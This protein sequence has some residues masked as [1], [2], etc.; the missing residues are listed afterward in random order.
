MNNKNDKNDNN[1]DEEAMKPAAK[2]TKNGP[3]S[4]FSLT[5]D[6]K[7]GD[8]TMTDA[9]DAVP[10]CSRQNRAVDTTTK[11]KKKKKGNDR[12]RR[13]PTS[14]MDQG[15]QLAPDGCWYEPVSPH[16]LPPERTTFV[17][18]SQTNG[19]DSG[20]PL[21]PGLSPEEDTAFL[22]L[23][24]GRV[25]RTTNIRTSSSTPRDVEHS[26][27][28]DNEDDNDN[29]DDEDDIETAY[30]AFVAPERHTE[31][32]RL[33][34]LRQLTE[35]A[36]LAVVLPQNSRQEDAGNNEHGQRQRRK[37]LRVLVVILLVVLVVVSAITIVVVSFTTIV[38]NKKED[39]KNEQDSSL[40]PSAPPSRMASEAPTR[41][42]VPSMAPTT[43]APTSDAFG[44]M[45]SRLFAA[46]PY[47]DRPRDS[48]SPQ[49]KAIL[50]LVDEDSLFQNDNKTEAASFTD[51]QLSRR[52]ALAT[53]Y[54]ATNGEG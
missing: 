2:D 17:A 54:Y 37:T 50:W 15:V 48:T 53:L 34:A 8:A 25:T 52:Y 19:K 35:N 9:P 31:A 46:H 12:R 6:E 42:A 44:I 26:D 28:Q 4:P 49:W 36:P 13:N 1:D 38:S 29:G 10:M 3:S 11:N 30:D 5:S 16:P 40:V 32:D 18:S 51:H 24:E 23:Q 33:A 21:A 41:S 22:D 27:R 7:D 47:Q 39:I 43:P 14:K 45:A 20:L